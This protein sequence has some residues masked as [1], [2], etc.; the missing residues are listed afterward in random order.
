MHF[1]EATARTTSCSSPW[2]LAFMLWIPV[3]ISRAS[4]IGSAPRCQLVQE[5]LSIA[6]APPRRLLRLLRPAQ[7]PAGATLPVVAQVRLPVVIAHNLPK[8]VLLL[9][10]QLSKFLRGH[11]HGEVDLAKG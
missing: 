6:T 10:G 7:A 4:G 11:V 5:S 1:L 3:M 2:N 8:R 9:L